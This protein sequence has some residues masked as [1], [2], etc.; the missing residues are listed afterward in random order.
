MKL[1]IEFEVSPNMTVTEGAAL[2]TKI[3]ALV[4]SKPKLVKIDGKVFE[5]KAEEKTP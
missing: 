3:Q 1:T 4:K 2:L 5:A